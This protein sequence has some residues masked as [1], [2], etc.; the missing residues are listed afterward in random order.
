MTAG[1]SISDKFY[2][3]AGVLFITALFL[4]YDLYTSEMYQC[5]RVRYSSPIAGRTRYKPKINKLFG[6]KVLDRDIDFDINGS[7]VIVFLHIQKTGGTTFGK[8]LVKHLEHRCDCSNKKSKRCDCNRPGTRVGDN[9]IWLFSRYSTGWSC[10]LHADWTELKN[11]VP[12]VL[13][14]KENNSKK[15]RYFYVTVLRDPVQRYISEWR[16][17]QRGA[18]WKKARHMCDGRLPSKEELP[19]CFTGEN[20]L[21]V[22]LDEFMNCKYNLANNRQ[23]RMLADLSL[24]GCYNLTKMPDEE[25]KQVMLRSAKR[26]LRRLAFF[27]LTEYQLESQFLFEETFKLNFQIPFEQMNNTKAELASATAV[28]PLQYERI[29]QLNSLDIDLYTFAR[30]LFIQRKALMEAK[31]NNNGMLPF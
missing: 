25:R 26:K 22:P 18:T 21:H 3:F 9:N 13:D 2:I 1:T 6:L 10:G 12:K 17:M 16:H 8:H 24:V 31:K 11:C 5:P 7:D 14:D 4:I 20:W 23:T 27:G 29:K 28:T 30:T 19:S 15:R